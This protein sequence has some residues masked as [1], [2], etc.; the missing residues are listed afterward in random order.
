MAN[1]QL[2]PSIGVWKGMVT[3]KG[4][5]HESMFEI[6]NSNGPWAMLFGKPLL[7]T[8]NA[9]HDYMENTI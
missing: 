1:G 6:F 9:I 2:V 3:V 4:I 7:R 8:F 5:S